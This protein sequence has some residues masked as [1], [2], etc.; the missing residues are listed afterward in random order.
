MKKTQ[1]VIGL[2]AAVILLVLASVTYLKWDAI[3]QRGNPL[4]YL[5]AM[6][7]LSGEKPYEAVVNMDGVYV[8]R[9]DEKEG[10][11]QMIQETYDVKYQDQL[12][13]S[14]LFSDGAEIH[15]VG[16][17][18]YWGQFTVWTLPFDRG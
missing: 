11:F 2:C 3:F 8:T 1:K 14:Y 9:R 15:M 7:K 17:E 18:I 4:P 16:S 6:I 5:A 13:S 10:L 12:G